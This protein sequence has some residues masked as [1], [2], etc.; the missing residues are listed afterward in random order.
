M[1]TLSRLS[2]LDSHTTQNNILSFHTQAIDRF[3]FEINE[4]VP[5]PLIWFVTTLLIWLTDTQVVWLEHPSLL[6]R[7]EWFTSTN[8]FCVNLSLDNRQ[9]FTVQSAWFIFCEYW[10][11][12]SINLRILY[13]H[14]VTSFSANVNLVAWQSAKF[15]KSSG[16]H[17]FVKNKE[18]LFQLLSFFNMFFLPQSRAQKEWI[19]IFGWI[20]GCSL[21]G[22]I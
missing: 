17:G 22:F 15:L 19:L 3:A 4:L 10:Y 18:I 1:C 13:G 12:V 14:G 6:L 9:E 5:S 8:L 2:T 20:S 11:I 21:Y 16:P 7:V